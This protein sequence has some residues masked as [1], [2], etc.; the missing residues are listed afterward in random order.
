MS[1]QLRQAI[2]MIVRFIT[3]LRKTGGRPRPKPYMI[4]AFRRDVHEAEKRNR[5]FVDDFCAFYRDMDESHPRGSNIYG[6]GADKFDMAKGTKHAAYRILV[7]FEKSS[8][9]IVFL[10]VYPKDDEERVLNKRA[11]RELKKL[12]D[13]VK[14][15]MKELIPLSESPV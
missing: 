1:E 12:V 6:T 8:N 10:S 2:A 9:T 5:G 7:Y 4:D 15:R 13:L 14:A 3:G 11:R